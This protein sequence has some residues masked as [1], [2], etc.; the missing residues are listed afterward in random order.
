MLLVAIAR[1][2]ML[3]RRLPQVIR[4]H[5][6]IS[7]TTLANMDVY[8]IVSVGPRFPLNDAISDFSLGHARSI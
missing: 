7:V 4:R 5:D 2:E 8:W 6:V 3:L 1:N